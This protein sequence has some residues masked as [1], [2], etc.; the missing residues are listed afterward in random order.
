[1]TPTQHP[2]RQTP[3][4]PTPDHPTPDSQHLGPATQAAIQITDLM[5]RYGPITAVSGLSLTVPKGSIYGF[6]GPNGAGKTTTIKALLGFRRPDGGSATV[7]G[8]DTVQRS[9]EV[10]ARTGYVSESGSVYDHLSADGM[11][12]FFRSTARHWQQGTFE[13]FLATFE[14]P[15]RLRIGRL[16]RGQKMQL[17]FALAMS[18]DPELLILDEPTAG[19]DPQARRTLLDALV[20]EVAAQGKTVF[21]SSHNLAEV[22]SVADSVGIL[23]SG[24]LLY[25]GSL[26]DLKQRHKI[27]Q[28]TYVDSPSAAQLA[29]LGRL[30][31]VTHS[32]QEGRTLRLSVQGD[33]PALIQTIRLEAAGLRDLSTLDQGLEDLFLALTKRDSP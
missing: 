32:Q 18:G 8:L 6:L 15:R 25:S 10:R 5:L 24:R 4:H 20:A 17:A 9:S 2:G 30:P 27:L 11:G 29:T 22:E 13:R 26:D 28:L 1:M 31:G 19:L 16:S 14:V 3:D 21:F 23:R 33:V 12:Q 7:L